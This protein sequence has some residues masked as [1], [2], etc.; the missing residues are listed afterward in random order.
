M[1]EKGVMQPKNSAFLL[2][3]QKIFNFPHTLQLFGNHLFTLVKDRR[4]VSKTTN[5][6]VIKTV[7]NEK[8]T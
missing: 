2:I 4:V 8:G 6:L 1:C 3:A 5:L 7:L